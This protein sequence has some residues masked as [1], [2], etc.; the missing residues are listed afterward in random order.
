MCQ[1][2]AG[3]FPE[4]W[5]LPLNAAQLRGLGG[6]GGGGEGAAAVSKLLSGDGGLGAGAG[7]KRHSDA[8][9]LTPPVRIIEMRWPS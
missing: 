4:Q 5:Q 9:G 2:G 1:R 3:V 7:A 6:G 8:S